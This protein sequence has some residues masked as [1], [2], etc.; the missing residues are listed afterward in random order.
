MV[1]TMPNI[2]I[3][4][5]LNCEFPGA[6]RQY[7][8]DAQADLHSTYALVYDDYKSGFWFTQQI[9]GRSPETQII[10]RRYFPKDANGG[11]DGNLWEAP[12]GSGT[13]QPVDLINFLQG[14]NAPPYVIHQLL[15][16]PAPHGDRLRVKN[17][18][19]V[20]CIKEASRRGLRLCVDNVQSVVIEQSELDA[21]LYDDL[22]RALAQHSEHILG[23]HEYGLGDLWFNTSAFGMTVLTENRS[24][25]VRAYTNPANDSVLQQE[26]VRKPSEAHLG[27]VEIIAQ[28]CRKIGVPMPKVVYTECGWDDVRLSQRNTVALMNELVPM[29]Y[30]TM[31]QYWSTRYPQWTQAQTAFEQLRWLNRAMPSYVVGACVF[32]FDTSFE[33]GAYHVE[34]RTL[35]SLLKGYSDELR[36]APPQTQPRPPVAPPAPIP[37][38]PVVNSPRGS[39][40]PHEQSVVDAEIRNA[41]LGLIARLAKS[42]NW[43]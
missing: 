17:A 4:Y 26:Y 16:E 37:A 36:A 13:L 10:H 21:G 1:G 3:G 11:W 20:E 31:A 23:I 6:N 39:Y 33:N 22:L 25:D 19:L 15:C 24:L 14:L 30:P 29:G 7:A 9:Y 32:A 8:A 27:R 43:L 34:D 41:P 42:A 35:Q 5:H 38:P 2:R 28:R 40:T 12:A 18:W